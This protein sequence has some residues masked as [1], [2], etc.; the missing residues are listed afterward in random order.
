MIVG[1]RA[2]SQC[3][4]ITYLHWAI[5]RNV[6]HLNESHSMEALHTTHGELQW[7]WIDRIWPRSCLTGNVSSRGGG[8][9]DLLE[10]IRTHCHHGILGTINNE[11]SLL[12]GGRERLCWMTLTGR[13]ELLQIS[14]FPSATFSLMTLPRSLIYTDSVEEARETTWRNKTSVC[15]A[16]M[17]AWTTKR[18]KS[19]IKSKAL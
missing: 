3:I 5:R 10:D 16:L 19:R 17:V 15:E 4:V 7:T 2:R 8:L 12:R 11:R 1:S 6:Y 13:G 14:P 18:G 9:V